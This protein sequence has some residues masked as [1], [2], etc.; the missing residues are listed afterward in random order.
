MSRSVGSIAAP[1]GASAAAERSTR[2]A[3][4]VKRHGPRCS[5]SVRNCRG[6]SPSSVTARHVDRGSGSF[7]EWRR[8]SFTAKFAA[9]SRSPAL[10]AAIG[11]LR[12]N[13]TF[14]GDEVSDRLVESRLAAAPRGRAAICGSL[15]GTC[16]SGVGPQAA[17]LI[18]AE[19]PVGKAPYNRSSRRS[20]GDPESGPS[21]KLRTASAT[22]P[23]PSRSSH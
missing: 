9:H 7:Q 18:S 1:A 22:R 8:G 11:S 13:R 6:G 17:G 14:N 16:Q 15:P 5:A 20:L 2:H 12:Q 3:S 21:S 10:T 23:N 19:L 4:G